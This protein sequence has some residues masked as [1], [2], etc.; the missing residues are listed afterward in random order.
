MM[1]LKGTEL[2]QKLQVSS[3]PSHISKKGPLG[4]D[5]AI[6]RV[7]RWFLTRGKLTGG[8]FTKLYR[9]ERFVARAHVGSR[10]GGFAAVGTF[11]LRICLGQT[12]SHLVVGVTS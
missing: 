10:H 8:N 2:S 1:E 6:E 5:V 12:T 11:E 9:S 3:S 4:E 7:K